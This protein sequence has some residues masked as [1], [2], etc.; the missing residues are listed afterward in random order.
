MM[1]RLPRPTPRA[2][3]LQRALGHFA[4][5]LR[6]ASTDERTKTAF[7]EVAIARLAAEAARNLEKE[8]R[9]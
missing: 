7:V 6:V 1:R 3:P 4:E 8:R 9:P 2:T 5:A